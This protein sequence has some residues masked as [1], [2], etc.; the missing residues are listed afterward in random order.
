MIVGCLDGHKDVVQC[1]KR[2][3]TSLSHVLSGSCDGQVWANVSD[4]II[5]INVFMA[6]VW[7]DVQIA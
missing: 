6:S 4:F 1:L 2:H 7:Y 3:P 5:K